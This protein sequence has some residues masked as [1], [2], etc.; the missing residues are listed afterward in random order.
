MEPQGKEEVNRQWNRWTYLISSR[1]RNRPRKKSPQSVQLVNIMYG[2][3]KAGGQSKRVPYMGHVNMNQNTLAAHVH[4]GG[5]THMDGN[6]NLLGILVLD[7][8]Y[9]SQ[10][11][12]TNLPVIHTKNEQIDFAPIWRHGLRNSKRAGVVLQSRVTDSLCEDLA[13]SC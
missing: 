2:C 10:T 9:Q 1:S 6:P 4:I 3:T 5:R 13:E 7:S 11:V 8:E 12:Q